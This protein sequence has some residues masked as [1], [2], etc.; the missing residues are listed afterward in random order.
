MKVSSISTPALAVLVSATLGCSADR[1]ASP[2]DRTLSPGAAAFG[3]VDQNEASTYTWHVN[4]TVT[5]ASNGD[6][7]RLAGTG[8]LGLH[9]KSASGGGT[10]THTKADGTVV[11][12]TWSVTELLS[13]QSYGPSPLFPTT[14]NGVGGK[15][16]LR[17][18][19]TPTGTTIVLE[20]IMDVECALPG[21]A[22]PGGTVE[23]VN[24]VVPG[25][26]NF[27]EPVSGSTLFRRI[28]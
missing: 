17:V 26:A 20:G 11:S 22:F 23:G 18:Q 24:L 3:A 16:E 2:S 6:R 13:F 9:P 14:F 10:F 12:G 7:I 15:A 27:N 19:L 5:E 25:V 8:P 21:S 1:I 28:S 4:N